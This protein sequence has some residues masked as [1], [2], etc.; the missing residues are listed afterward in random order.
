MID[1]QPP[2]EPRRVR[3]PICLCPGV[4][5]DAVHH[6][7]LLLLGECPRCDHR[8]T[9]ASSDARWEREF[10][11]A[12][13]SIVLVRSPS[14]DPDTQSWDWPGLPARDLSGAA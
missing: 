11:S 8:W 12:P 9:S 4:R 13:R 10:H 7:G 14:H 5:T 1:P 6:G 2:H 3:C